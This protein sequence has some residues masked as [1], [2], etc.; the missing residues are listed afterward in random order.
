M[1]LPQP[2]VVGKHPFGEIRF[3][4]A[5]HLDMRQHPHLI[6]FS[7]L[8]FDPFISVASPQLRIPRHP[9]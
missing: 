3:V 1:A 9:S 4:P 8:D 5:L 2:A 6:T 7:P